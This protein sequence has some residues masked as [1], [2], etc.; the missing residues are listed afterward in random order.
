MGVIRKNSHLFNA[1]FTFFGFCFLLFPCIEDNIKIDG[2]EMIFGYKNKRIEFLSFNPLGFVFFVILIISIG[3]PIFYN[4]KNKKWSIYLHSLLL[5]FSTVVYYLL[6]L[7]I[8]NPISDLTE[9]TTLANLY[10]GASFVALSFIIS[11][12]RIYLNVKGEKYNER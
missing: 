1:L 6:P 2:I 10:I 5:L 9:Y 11:L 12:I 8:V 4:E 3:V 7:T